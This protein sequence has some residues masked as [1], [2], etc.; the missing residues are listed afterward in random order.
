MSWWT[1]D[2]AM[3]Q[4]PTRILLDVLLHVNLIVSD[5]LLNKEI[6]SDIFM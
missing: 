2:V 3:D 1:E 6:P 5:Q 4:F